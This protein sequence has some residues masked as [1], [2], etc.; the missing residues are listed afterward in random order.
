M[1]LGIL[2]TAAVRTV[3]VGSTAQIMLGSLKT[4]GATPVKEERPKS[5]L[6]PPKRADT[7]LRTE[8]P[9]VGYA[10]TGGP[11]VPSCGEVTPLPQGFPARNSVGYAISAKSP[12]PHVG[13]LC[14]HLHRYNGMPHC[15]SQA[16]MPL[17]GKINTE[18]NH[19][20]LLPGD[21]SESLA[22]QSLG[23]AGQKLHEEFSSVDV[24]PFPGFK[25]N[26]DEDQV[27]NIIT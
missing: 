21:G 25:W 8:G 27:E 2:K 13:F 14:K 17:S 20:S 19:H 3:G 12:K 11:S 4:D 23:D 15:F 1:T 16:G 24:S 18:I 26:L 9:R 10:G 7:K 5:L 22:L 6:P